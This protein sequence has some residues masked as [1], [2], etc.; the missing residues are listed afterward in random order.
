MGERRPACARRSAVVTTRRRPAGAKRTKS[1]SGASGQE[2]PLG[3]GIEGRRL[4]LQLLDR[5]ETGGA[6]ANLLVPAELGRSGLSQSDRGMVTDLVYGTVRRQRALDFAVDRFLVNDPPTAARLAL[7]MG[8]YQ[9]L[10][11]KTAPHAAVS[12]TVGAAPKRFR[13]LI[14]AVLR[15]VAAGGSDIDWP[16]LATELSYPDWIVERLTADHGAER[17]RAMLAAMN[18]PA[19]V[20]VR[21]DGY[22]QDP[23]SQ[24]ITDLILPTVGEIVVDLCAAP[25]GKATGIA[26]AAQHSGVDC[27]IVAAD[28]RHARTQLMARNIVS[29]GAQGVVAL[30]A[31][32]RR[33]AL[34]PASA[35]WV[36]VD[37]PCSG[38]GVLRRR[39]DSRWRVSPND[40]DQ[41]AKVQAGLL[42]SAAGL[43][44]LGGMLVYSVCTLTRAETV[45]LI[46]SFLA[47]HPEFVAQPIG[48]PFAEW[49]AGG[50]L[51]PTS[52]DTDGMAAFVLRRS[53]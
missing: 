19:E 16:D 15:R 14:N 38:L 6:Y 17:A 37:A 13:G 48:Q 1:A 7:R 40:V 12:A 49:G 33:P 18:A 41:L 47:S 46:D 26:A 53:R 42:E 3:S 25:G 27:L 11:R 44:R 32:G 9:L 5:I 8:A 50:L 43:V 45:I 29:T 28:S 24:A 21:A 22:T 35:D 2:A 20:H 39:P 30:T 4:A 51:D 10:D 34:R 31:D 52:G 23:G 36:L